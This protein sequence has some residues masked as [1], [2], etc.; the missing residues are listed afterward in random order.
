MRPPG[1]AGEDLLGHLGGLP[2]ERGTEG[3][4]W[5][6]RKE[7]SS[8]Q[9]PQPGQETVVGSRSYK[10]LSPT[11]PR[12]RFREPHHLH[13]LPSCSLAPTIMGEGVRGQESSCPMHRWGNQ[14]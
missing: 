4:G 3:K 10:K 11:S 5:N 9:R 7:R 8:T 1:A 6:E 14:F 13:G 2:G 12:R